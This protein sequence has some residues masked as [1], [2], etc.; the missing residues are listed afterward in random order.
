MISQISFLPNDNHLEIWA[1][2]IQFNE[3][4]EKIGIITNPN[5]N[6]P[7]IEFYKAISIVD[8]QMILDKIKREK[9]K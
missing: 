6:N 8:I 1:T 5:V 7:K 4:P 9:F 3:L 2:T